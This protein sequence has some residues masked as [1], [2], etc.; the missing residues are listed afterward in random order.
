MADH[1]TIYK[2]DLQSIFAGKVITAFNLK[3]SGIDLGTM[4]KFNF[5]NRVGVVKPTFGQL[6]PRQMWHYNDRLTPPVSIHGVMYKF[7]WESVGTIYPPIINGQMW[8]RGD[9]VANG[10]VE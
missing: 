9:Y 8:P 6:W 5:H 4:F 10:V 7:R 3:A 1:G 2:A